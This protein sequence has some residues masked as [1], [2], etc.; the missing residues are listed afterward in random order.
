MAVNTQQEAINYLVKKYPF[1]KEWN[2]SVSEK[3][4]KDAHSDELKWDFSV[5]VIDPNNSQNTFQSNSEEDLTEALR[6]MDR[7]LKV[8]ALLKE[9]EIKPVVK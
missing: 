1:I 8:F 6:E 3:C 4:R 9:K 5:S 7:Q 2:I